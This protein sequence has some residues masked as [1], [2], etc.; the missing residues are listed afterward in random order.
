MPRR[1]ARRGGRA[2]RAPWRARRSRAARSA[3]APPPCTALAPACRRRG[4]DDGCCR[5]TR[6]RRGAGRRAWR[7]YAAPGRGSEGR[8]GWPGRCWRYGRPSGAA[9]G[10]SAGCGCCRHPR[11]ARGGHETPRSSHGTAWRPRSA[12]G[13]STGKPRAAAAPATAHRWCG[14]SAGTAPGSGPS[15]N[16]PIGCC[17]RRPSSSAS[18]P[19]NAAARCDGRAWM[20]MRLAGQACATVCV[21]ARV[22]RACES[23]SC[24]GSY[25]RIM[26]AR[27]PAP[28]WRPG[29]RP[30]PAR[31][32]LPEHPSPGSFITALAAGATLPSVTDPSRCRGVSR[33]RTIARR[34]RR[35]LQRPG[36]TK[37]WAYKTR[38]GNSSWTRRAA[39]STAAG[40]GR[41][42][43]GGVPWTRR[44]PAR[45]I[46][47]SWRRRRNCA[48]SSRC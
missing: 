1:C 41:V 15:P 32:R 38:D 33:H 12:A 26:R 10:A 22:N 29:Q 2:R 35:C 45:R 3:A 34:G 39:G 8:G 16:S 47:P 14:G 42:W 36:P 28:S 21:K 7:R 46:G 20:T 27:L 30:P 5:C 19:A 31:K 13:G 9:G 18:G 37:T 11:A 40:I 17:V 48:S 24:S 44:R 43:Q 6:R 25:S 4:R 23:P